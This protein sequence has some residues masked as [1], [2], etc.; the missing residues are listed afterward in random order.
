MASLQL[1]P[2]IAHETN[3]GTSGREDFWFIVAA[4]SEDEAEIRAG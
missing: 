1:F 4:R 3:R 2:V